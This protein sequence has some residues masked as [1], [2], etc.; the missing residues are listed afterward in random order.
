MAPL[1]LKTIENSHHGGKMATARQLVPVHASGSSYLMACITCF[2]KIR[3]EHSITSDKQFQIWSPSNVLGFPSC[4]FGPCRRDC[5]CVGCSILSVSRREPWLFQQVSGACQTAIS[6]R[7]PIQGSLPRGHQG[8][9]TVLRVSTLQKLHCNARR[10][11][12][13]LCLTI[14]TI[15]SSSTTTTFLTCFPQN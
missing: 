9:R 13:P 5:G 11:P 15:A 2:I 7:Q 3:Q 6:L 14:F 10:H 12:I 8:S 4:R 1:Q